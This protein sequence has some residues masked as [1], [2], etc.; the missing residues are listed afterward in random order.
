MMKSCR[1]VCRLVSESMDRKLS[2]WEKVVLGFHLGMRKLCAS[3]STNLGRLRDVVRR[4]AREIESGTSAF[5]VT[6]SDE[7]RQ[8]IKRAMEAQD[9]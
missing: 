5:E 7:A 1:E 2:L 4:H 9:R 3:F 8:R 6:L